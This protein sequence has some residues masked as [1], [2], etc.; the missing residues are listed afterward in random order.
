MLRSIHE[1]LEKAKNAV[2][3][4][5]GSRFGSSEGVA[6]V[7]IALIATTSF[8]LGML[9]EHEDVPVTLLP[10]SAIFSEGSSESLTSDDKA[11]AT[12]N[13]SARV[14]GGLLVASK[15]GTK[16][17]LPWCAGARTIKEE[18]KI[19]FPSKEEAEAAGYT[20]AANC[21]GL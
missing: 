18:N 19:W 11:G 10:A 2:G 3:N 17:H 12:V 14:A 8:A 13:E 7:L 20:A 4:F 6:V 21:K 9:S 1:T 15:Q 5:R 16:Y